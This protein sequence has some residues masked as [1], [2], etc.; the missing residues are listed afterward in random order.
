MNMQDSTTRSAIT[1]DRRVGQVIAFFE[2]LSPDA[3]QRLDE[4]LQAGNSSF[5]SLAPAGTPR[6]W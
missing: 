5:G 4:I 2:T 6:P 3:L 1:T